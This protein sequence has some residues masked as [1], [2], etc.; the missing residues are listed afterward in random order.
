MVD[1]VLLA[2]GGA[3]NREQSNITSAIYAFLHHKW[4]FVEDMPFEC[5]YLD[6]LL[7]TG[8]RLLMVDGYNRHVWK[9]TVKGNA[10]VH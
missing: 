2:I 9:V 1:G 10:M 3:V 5:A 6:T 7:L 4:Q 8:G